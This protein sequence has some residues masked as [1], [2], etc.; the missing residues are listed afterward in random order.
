MA[1]HAPA[2]QNLTSIYIPADRRVA[3]AYGLELPRHTTGAALFA[4]ISGF[5]PLTETLKRALG[6]RHGAERLAQYLNQVY[7]ALIANVDAHGGSVIGFSGDAITCWFDDTF[8]SDVYRKIVDEGIVG[9]GLC[10]CPPPACPPAAPRAAACA[11]AMIEAMKQFAELEVPGQGVFALKVK[12]AVAQGPVQRLLAGNPDYQVID[13]A[14][15]ETML[16]MAAAEHLAEKGQVLVDA[17]TRESLGDAL[18]VMAERIDTDTGQAY[19]A[20]DGYSGPSPLAPWPSIPANAL[21]EEQVIP[22]LLP[23][24]YDRLTQGLGEFLTELRPAVALFLRFTGIEFES[25]PDAGARLDAYIRWVQAVVTRYDGTFIQLTIGEK[26]SYLYVA[27]GAPRAHEDDPWRAVNAA[28]ELRNSPSELECISQV[29]I[30]LSMGTMRTGAYGSKT[31]RTYGVLGDDVNLAARLMQ[32]AEPGQ[33][34]VSGQ[35]QEAVGPA[36]NWQILAPMQI[37]GKR[38]PVPVAILL[39]PAGYPDL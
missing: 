13:S 3:L 22:W 23:P 39:G 1:D 25:D 7:D 4:D 17:H 35:I 10:A 5:T 24:I 30:G 11:L 14:A 34:L 20:I 29:Q 21:P 16:R 26:G 8:I 33:I 15:G 6:E 19:Y 2:S 18:S 32:I 9:A 28:L 31:R 38:E 36:C 12:V 27:F 37:K